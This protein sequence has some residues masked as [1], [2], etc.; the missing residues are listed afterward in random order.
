MT[1]RA[2][3]QTREV[4]LLGST[5]SEA[6]VK[7]IATELRRRIAVHPNIDPTLGAIE[8][9][10]IN[11]NGENFACSFLHGR[12]FWKAMFRYEGDVRLEALELL[13]RLPE[14]R[15]DPDQ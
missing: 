4:H 3:Q 6:E 1:V 10:S 2:V 11:S 7:Q 8:F 15:Q 9:L 14:G 5:F 12:G 13:Q